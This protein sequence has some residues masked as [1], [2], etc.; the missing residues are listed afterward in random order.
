MSFSKGQ[1]VMYNSKCCT[2]FL[3]PGKRT[4]G[5]TV[6]GYCLRENK[7]GTVHDNIAESQITSCNNVSVLN[8]YWPD[9]VYNGYNDA[10]SNWIIKH[11]VNHLDDTGNINWDTMLI[12]LNTL[13]QWVVK[14]GQKIELK[15]KYQIPYL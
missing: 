10:A 4:N 2:V 12:I 8:D 3:V 6:T 9:F 1:S 14:H 5:V 15:K 7:N 13:L 11:I